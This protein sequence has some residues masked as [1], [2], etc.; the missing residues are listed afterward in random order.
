AYEADP[1]IREVIDLIASGFFC[2]E[3]RGL[4]QPLLDAILGLDP[5]LTLVDFSAYAACQREVEVAYADQAGWTRKAALNIARMGVFSSDRTIREY[6]RE[7]WRVES[8][9]VEDD[10]PRSLF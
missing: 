7:I 10:G 1:V 8:V 3:D 4:F 2:P 6:G 9:E 5:Y